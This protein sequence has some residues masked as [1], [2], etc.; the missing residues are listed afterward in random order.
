MAQLKEGRTPQV[1]I[2]NKFNSDKNVQQ[3][4]DSTID[5]VSAHLDWWSC[6]C[7]TDAF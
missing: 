2:I 6:L 1:N 7:I 4:F 3:A 5:D